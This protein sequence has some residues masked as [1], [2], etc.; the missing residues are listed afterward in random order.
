MTQSALH[1][2]TPIAIEVPDSSANC[3]NQ[4]QNLKTLGDLM[5]ILGENPPRDFAALRT[6]CTWLAVHLDKAADQITIDAVDETRD[7]FRPFLQS[8][9]FTKNTIKKYVDSV[10]VL[11]KNA[12]ELGWRPDESVPEE[13]RGVL[14][15]AAERNCAD[16]AKYLAKIRI[17]PRDVTIEDVDGWV[18][19]CVKNQLSCEYSEN[20]RTW[21]WR[22]LR[23]CGCTDQ[24]PMCLLREKRYGVPLELFP[25]V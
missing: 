5:H 17:T 19:N 1:F 2:G 12:K 25:R 16:L 4:V 15:L 13:W 24:T 8:R 3:T 14:A 23:D 9:K 18:Q 11:L 21:F 7:G 20:K 22:L 10:R 6:A